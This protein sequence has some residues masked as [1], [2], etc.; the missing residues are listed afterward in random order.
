MLSKNSTNNWTTWIVLNVLTA[1]LF[2]GNLQK[3]KVVAILD[4][5]MLCLDNFTAGYPKDGGCDEGPA[6]WG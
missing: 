5:A 6:Y 1:V 3:S 4:K 2:M